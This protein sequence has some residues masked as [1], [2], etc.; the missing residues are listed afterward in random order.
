M[1]IHLVTRL[2]MGGATQLV[3]DITKRMHASGQDVLILTGL[4]NKQTS[5]SAWNNRVLTAVKEAGI[6]VEVC[7][8]LQHRI[9][10]PNDFRALLW[11]VAKLK[12]HRPT[13]VHIHSSKA[14]ILG[15][16]AARLSGVERVVFHV[17]GWSFSSA[18]G[19]LRWFYLE[20]EKA[21]DRITP[22]YIFVS[23]QDMLDFV[24]LGGD[25]SID[26]RSHVIYPGTDFGALEAGK[27]RRRE[28]RKAYGFEDHHHVIGSIGRLDYQK[29]PQLFVTI[30]SQYAKLNHDA[31]F[32]WIG[33]G[34]ELDDV[35]QLISDLDLGDRFTLM[36]FVEDVDAYYHVFDTFALTSRYEGLPLAVIRALA[37]GT[38]VVEFL[39]NGMI[40]LDQQFRSVLGVPHGDIEGFVSQLEVARHMSSAERPMLEAE[41]RWVRENLNLDCMYE[42]IMNVYGLPAPVAS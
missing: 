13:V 15:R 3:Y 11:L 33:E 38:P 20:L 5:L 36:G 19:L 27:G 42:A 23:R 40:D 35:E 37:A 31:R 32:A 7:P 4:S 14:G 9:S 30:A 21:F 22:E 10:L 1:V 28:I 2:P 17:H 24:Q 8:H 6:P 25:P 18:K 29:N 16:L 34:V 39:S 41:S 12:E 26:R